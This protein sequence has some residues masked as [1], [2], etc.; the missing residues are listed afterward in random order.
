MIK[1]PFIA[2]VTIISLL[3]GGS[4][5]A[6]A[7]T[8]L[9]V[10]AP[11]LMDVVPGVLYI[12]LKAKHGIDFEHLSPA[13]T[14]NAML[15]ELFTSIGVTEVDPFDPDAKNY[16]VAC[17]HGIDRMFVIH[18][19]GEGRT[20]RTAGLDFLKLDC[21]EAVSPRYI[22]QKCYTPNDPHIQDQYALDN[23]HMHILDAWGISKGNANIIIADLDEGVNYNHEDLAG[24]IFKIGNNFGYDIVGE[25]GTPGHFLP[26]NDPMPGPNQ[27][28]GTFTTGC[29]GMVPDN[30]LGGAGSGFN[31]KIMAIKI[32]DD[33][34]NLYGGYEGIQYAIAHGAK[35]LN[36]SWG[37]TETNLDF[38]SFMQS[39][40][41]EATD[42]GVLVVAAAG[43]FTLN[44]DIAA[45]HF[46]PA[47]LKG[48]LAVGA[49]DANDKPANFSNFGNAVGC[50]APGVN[51][52]STTF[53]GN[54]SY[55][56]SSGTSFSCPLTS[57]VAG[58][59]WGKN[60]TW[61]PKFVMRQIIETCEN[62]VNPANRTFYWGR[63]N[64]YNALSK[65]TVPGLG[66]TD[67]KIDGV[68]KGGLDYANKEYT[69]DVTF[70]NYMSAGTGIQAQLLP[71]DGTVTLNG[72]YTVQLGTSILGAMSAQQSLVGSFKFTRDGTDNGAGSQLPLY[73]AISYGT[74]TVEGA[75]YYDTLII[76]VNI[77]GDN[78]Y[79]SSV[80]PRENS[81]ILQLG[82]TYP[83]PV[84][85]DASIMFELGNTESAKLSISDVLGRTVEILS[86]GIFESGSH[87][88][89]FDAHALQNGVY[90]YKLET[91]DGAVM[92]KQFVVVH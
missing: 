38:I 5:V 58:L 90:L 77:T 70:K 21:I 14:G 35:I 79:V 63:V 52:F 55:D 10:S 48:V 62:V 71:I 40:V 4:F 46:Y 28:H 92:T 11:K 36:C 42:T 2:I 67:Y 73:F 23:T 29:F 89:H 69:I 88:I 87:T 51:I 81:N 50:Y 59:V 9:S 80:V 27:S 41:D 17:R 43:N 33:S 18:F 61:S 91:A 65:A 45:N 54:S 32:A 57:G 31:C 16:P 39:I 82:N 22:F 24:N 86:E 7:Q 25:F 15:D 30:N 76:N 3:C 64:A 66:I 84:S 19:P 34:G 8:P 56:F 13:H 47:N 1:K 72:G 83:N 37:G 75:K 60:P 6:Y 49:T 26:D 78:I 12:K 74:S 68:D 20:P 85:T 44:I 53:P